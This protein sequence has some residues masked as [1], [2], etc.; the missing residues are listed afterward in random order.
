MRDKESKFNIFN[1]KLSLQDSS[2][3]K[4]TITIDNFTPDLG[5]TG[6]GIDYH[7]NSG[8]GNDREKINW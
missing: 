3:C 7:F 8:A 2:S 1:T 5:E 6:K 4:F